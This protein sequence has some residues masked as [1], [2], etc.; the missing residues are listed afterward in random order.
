MS[1]AVQRSHPATAHIDAFNQGVP[2]Q[3]VLRLLAG[4]FTPAD[5]RLYCRCPHWQ[6]KKAEAYEFWGR[7]CS[8]CDAPA[9]QIHHRPAGYR[10][11]FREDVHRHLVPLCRTCHRRHHRK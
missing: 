2:M 6:T 1:T 8:L 3:A 4:N 7:A 11:L 5:Y 10:N 9:V